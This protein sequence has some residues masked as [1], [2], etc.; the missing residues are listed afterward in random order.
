M[1]MIAL[2][3]VAGSDYRVAAPDFKGMI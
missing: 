3:V 1:T 2:G